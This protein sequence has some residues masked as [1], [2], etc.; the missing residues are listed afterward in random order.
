ML[1]KQTTKLLALSAFSYFALAQSAHAVTETYNIDSTHSFANFAIRH[2]VSKTSGS[3]N[4][5]KGKIQIDRDNMANSSI[6]ATIN[7]LS[8]DTGHAK[9]DEHIKKEEYLDVAKATEITF[10]STKVDAKSKTDGIITGKFTMHGVTKEI[11]FPFKVLGF[12]LDPWGGQRSGFEAKTVIKAS[13]YG[14]GWATKAGAPVGDDI[15]VTL[16]IEGVL[17][18]ENPGSKVLSK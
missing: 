1:V 17:S 10:V 15:E 13:D 3:F 18:V 6:N 11:S 8:I 9:R 7:I 5:I 4:D 16:L 2:V 14:F 12:G